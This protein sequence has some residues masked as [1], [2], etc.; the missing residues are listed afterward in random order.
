LAAAPTLRLR[1]QALYNAIQAYLIDVPDA[2]LPADLV[3][4]F[5]AMEEAWHAADGTGK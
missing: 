5:D 2:E 4:A 1:S 3:V